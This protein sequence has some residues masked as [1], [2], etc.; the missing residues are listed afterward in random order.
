MPLIDLI[1]KL[2]QSLPSGTVLTGE[3]MAR[4]TT[5]R[6]GGPADVMV[7]ADSGADIQKTVA[8]CREE[9]YP[10]IILGN[11]SNVLVRDGG[12]RGCVILMGEGYSC[13]VPS[14]EDA[15]YAHAGAR[16]NRFAETCMELGLAG[17]EFISG[18]PG[19]IGGA[20]FM[21]AGAYGSETSDIV[22][23]VRALDREG[24]F[25]E[26]TLEEMGFSYR[27]S[28]AAEREMII[29]GAEFQ[30]KKGN[31]AEIA[32]RIADL[33]GRRRDRQPLEYPSAGSVFKRPLGHFAAKLIDDAGLKGAR[34]GDAQVSE[35]HA[36]F[37]INRGAAAA[38]DVLELIRCIQNIVFGMFG[39][40]LETEV[41]ILGEEAL[42]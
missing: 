10:F 24:N 16:N 41:R 42:S 39:V 11:G 40:R 3:P 21:N 28:L 26:L 23:A 7:L 19:T 17:C 35:K 9:N 2:Q 32:A 27:H 34:V 1:D 6:V 12:I 38:A 13:V 33:N 20:V 14:G 36:G 29:L 4:H 8:L 30:L 18:I 22:K 31:P 5:F 37:I 15:V 25:L